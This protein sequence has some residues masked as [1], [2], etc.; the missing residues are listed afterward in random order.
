MVAA[1]APGA[2]TARVR[3]VGFP[4]AGGAVLR[5]PVEVLRLAGGLIASRRNDPG[6]RAATE[7]LLA[8]RLPALPPAVRGTRLATT[9]WLF[10]GVDTAGEFGTDRRAWS[11]RLADRA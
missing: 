2:I 1:D 5:G 6:G 4:A 11:A 8:A 10:R 3:P 7:P 9:S